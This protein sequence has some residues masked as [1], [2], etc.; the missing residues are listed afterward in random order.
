MT[1]EQLRS[2]LQQRE[3]DPVSYS[4]DEAL[5]SEKYVL[6]DKGAG[7]WSAIKVNAVGGQA[8][9]F[10][11]TRMPHVDTFS[12]FWKKIPRQTDGGQQA[13]A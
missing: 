13:H 1:K 5:P 8:R 12:R 10:S 2:I 3:F 7:R 9:R 4:L 11:T 6:F